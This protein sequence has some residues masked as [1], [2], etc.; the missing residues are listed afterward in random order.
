VLR[1][2]VPELAEQVLAE[3]GWYALAA[4]LPDA[5]AAGHDPATLL[6]G[7]AGRRV[8]DTAESVSDVLVWRLLHSAD[9]PASTNNRVTAG[10][11]AGRPPNQT[12]RT[13]HGQ[14]GP[15]RGRA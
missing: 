5:E 8:L 1:E 10:R 6:A 15:G 7:A 3:P 9:L 2:A 4:T 11:G 14:Y 13:T 12:G